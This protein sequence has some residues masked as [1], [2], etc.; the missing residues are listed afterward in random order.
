MVELISKEDLLDQ[1]RDY[2]PFLI[3]LTRDA[4]Q[5]S[6]KDVLKQIFGDKELRAYSFTYCFFGKALESKDKSLQDKFKVVC[7]T[8]TPLDQTDMLLKR[9]EGRNIE[10]KPYG[11]V[12]K[13]EFVI[14]NG[15]NPVFYMSRSLARS[16]WPLYNKGVEKQ[17]SDGENDLLALVTICEKWNDWHWEREWR[18]VGR[19]KF[20]LG[21]IFCGLCPEDDIQEFEYLRERVKFIDP[22]WGINKILDRLVNLPKSK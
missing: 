1:K 2:S 9:V 3:H 13:K 15:G 10:L 14:Q 16:L 20:K 8:E 22:S 18:T 12:F 19:L 7:F 11:L 21:D 4:K 5:F 17:F 6:A